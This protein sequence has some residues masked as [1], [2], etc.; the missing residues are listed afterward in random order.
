VV[1]GG[2][3]APDLRSSAV[4]LTDGTF[5]SI[6][7]DGALMP[8]GMPRFEEL[9]DSERNDLRQYIRSQAH[10]AVREN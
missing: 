10:A 3:H 1:I 2:G 6:V 8:N 4:P 9:T 7:Q 5:K